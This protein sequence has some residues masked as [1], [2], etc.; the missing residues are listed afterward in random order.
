MNIPDHQIIYVN[1]EDLDYEHINDAYKL[2]EF[3]IKNSR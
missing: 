2:N 1:F 3:A